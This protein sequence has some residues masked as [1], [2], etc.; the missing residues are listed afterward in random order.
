MRGP[1]ETCPG[2]GGR[3]IGTALITH[4]LDA[5]PFLPSPRTPDPRG[6]PSFEGRTGSQTRGSSSLLCLLPP[7]PQ[8]PTKRPCP[9]SPA[10]ARLPSPFLEKGPGE[11]L[12]IGPCSVASGTRGA[13]SPELQLTRP[14]PGARQDRQCPLSVRQKAASVRVGSGGGEDR[15]R[16][17]LG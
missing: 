10:W 8:Y 5:I 12:F 1:L 6:K 2:M 3:G 9:S 16:Q 4:S 14:S 13:R 17:G 11:G 7:P 15:P